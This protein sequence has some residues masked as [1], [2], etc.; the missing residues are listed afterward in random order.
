[1][2]IRTEE[3]FESFL[4][5]RDGNESVFSKLSKEDLAFF[6]SQLKFNKNGVPCSYWGDLL[7]ASRMSESE[8]FDIIS[9]IFGVD[10]EEFR[11]T[12]HA[13][14]DAQGNCIPRQFWNCPY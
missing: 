14:G 5:S 12:Y 11:G 6:R 1:M 9:Q 2:S 13:F 8:L 3:E 10:V 4:S 7:Q